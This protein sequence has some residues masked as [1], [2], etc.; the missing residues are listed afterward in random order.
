MGQRRRLAWAGVS[1][2]TWYRRK[3]A[4]TPA[5]QSLIVSSSLPEAIVRPSGEKATEA[6]MTACPCS[7]RSSRPL[8]ASQS[9]IVL[10]PLPEAIVRPSGEKA[11]ETTVSCPCS[12]RSSRPLAASQSLIVLSL[13]PEATVRPSGEKA[14]KFTTPVCPCSVR[15]SRTLTAETVAGVFDSAFAWVAAGIP[16]STAS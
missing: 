15:S 4:T 5:S 3:L 11:T 13:L 1:G 6:I 2:R 8:A 9:L 12:V 7:V 10:S 16:N 14:T